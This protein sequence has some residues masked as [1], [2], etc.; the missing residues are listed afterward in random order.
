VRTIDLNRVSAFV[1]VV[2]DGGFTKAAQSLGVPK[3]SVSRGVAQL[4]QELGVRLLQRTTRQ[5]HLTDAGTAFYDRVAR[6]LGDID[7]ATL[8]ASDEHAQLRGTVRITAPPDFGV[9]VLAPM[10]ARFV[11]RNPGIYVDVVLTGR[12]VD[13]VGEGFD[14]AVRAGILRDSSLVAR[15][16]GTLGSALYASPKYVARR[17]APKEVDELASF[18]CVLFRPQNGKSTVHLVRR[19]GEERDV[20]MRGP[21]AGDDFAFVRKAVIAGAGI[22]VLPEFLCAG[23]EQRGK[24]VRVLPEW[25]FEGGGALHVVYPSARFVPQRVV[26]LREHLVER[27][28]EVVRKC[29]RVRGKQDAA[30]AVS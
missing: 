9:G 19:G 12:V 27:L 6:A 26:A 14:L 2:Q 22:G 21:L 20:D 17:G 25:R 3:S 15:R 1:R 23:D 10:L 30:A 24:L 5:V 7:E 29:D 16:I 11:R 18:E 28:G 13:L 4:E 8:A